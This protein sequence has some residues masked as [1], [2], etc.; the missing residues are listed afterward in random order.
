MATTLTLTGL[1]GYV[2]ENAFELLS[3]A[4]L[5]TNL[6]QY[7]TVRAGLQGN[8]VDIPLLADD[9]ALTNDAAGDLTGYYCG[10]RDNGTTTISQV[11]MK[12]AH[13][14]LQ[15]AYC[16]NTLRD[17]FM[18]QQ[19][20]R[21]AQGGEESLPFEQVAASYFTSKVTNYNEVFLIQGATLGGSLSTDSEITY[22]GLKAQ[23]A[24]AV[25]ATTMTGLN[26]GKWVAGTAGSGEI[27]ALDA[28]MAVFDAAPAEIMMR[29]DNFLVVSHAAYKALIGAMV[30]ANLYNFVGNE[31]ELFI[32]ST[33]VRVVPSAGIASTDN[34]KLLTSGANI[35][36]G[37][38]LTSDFDEF[39]VWYS[40]DNDEVRASMKWAV[41]V[42]I[43]QPELCVA[44]DEQ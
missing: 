38:D 28:A 16:V 30:K 42:T 26:Q 32:P 23:A 37:T 31:R 24:A 19:L 4:V 36:M 21:G 40:Q 17:T 5:E 3:K 35:I 27:N 44:V 34:F 22:N 9:F 25:T 13:P 39:R 15:R 33:N 8:S 41:G 14:K 7:V 1:T 12:L 43:V 18:S 10:W 20:S 2:E 6:A 29:D 11:N